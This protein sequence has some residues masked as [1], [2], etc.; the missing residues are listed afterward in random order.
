MLLK[1]REKY[2]STALFKCDS[3]SNEWHGNYYILGKKEKHFCPSCSCK[4]GWNVKSKDKHTN[5]STELKRY[6]LKRVDEKELDYLPKRKN[7]KLII[8][9]S[10]CNSIRQSNSFDVLNK[11]S[12]LCIKCCDIHT[13]KKKE[14]TK[15][16]EKMAIILKQKKIKQEKEKKINIGYEYRKTPEYREKMREAMKHSIA[17][18][19]HS[20]NRIKAVKDYWK[21][22][23]GG[24]ELSEVYPEWKQYKKIVYNLTEQNYRKYKN[25]INPENLLRGK[26]KYHIDHMFS[27]LEGFKN[28]ILPAI[29]SNP[30][31]LHM[32][33]YKD[34]LSKDYRCSITKEKLFERRI[35]NGSTTRI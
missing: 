2:K 8:E 28:N 25:I 14:I 9:C 6:I 35:G 31:N 24:K 21:N 33:Y 15:E 17:W 10:K 5:I 18:K 30:S 3:C 7:L 16:K 11:Q 1:Q 12:T 27:V 23:R 32:M 29:I 13:K 26:N 34:N 20:H 19:E 4:N 22:I